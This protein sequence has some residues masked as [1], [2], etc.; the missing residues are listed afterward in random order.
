MARSEM[1]QI[2]VIGAGAM[3]Q[4]F[5]RGAVG[6]GFVSPSAIRVN[7]RQNEQ[8]LEAFRAIGVCAQR[9]KAV[10]CRDARVIL[11]AVKPKD[12]EQALA[13]LRPHVG[14]E[15]LVVSLMAGIPLRFIESRLGGAVRVVRAMANTSSAVRESATAVAGGSRASARDIQQA[16]ALLSAL[17]PVLIVDEESLDAVTALAG[18]GP[19]YVYLL[20]ESL[21]QAGSHVGLSDDVARQLALQTVYGAARMLV[22]TQSRPEELRRRV[23]SPGGTTEAALQILEA[24]GFRDALV[25]AISRAKER[26]MELGIPFRKE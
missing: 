16:V 9:D 17:G 6:S 23:T 2:G 11:L 3:A 24:A 26:S 4:S 22:E 1:L 7:N 18:S 5:V 13:E 20:L 10:L 25:Q 8:H 15:H 14:P 21:I 19:A 12:A